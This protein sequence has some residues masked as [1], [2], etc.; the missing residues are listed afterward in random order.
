M[1]YLKENILSGIKQQFYDVAIAKDCSQLLIDSLKDPINSLQSEIQ[2]L[3]EELKVKSHLVELTITS[4]KIDYSTTN[5]SSQ[6][7]GHHT[8][9]ISDKKGC[10]SININGNN[11]MYHDKTINRKGW[12]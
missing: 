5:P 9:N 7:I 1:K 6:Q 12:C 11:N 10:C 8:Q 2:F 4:K 3:W